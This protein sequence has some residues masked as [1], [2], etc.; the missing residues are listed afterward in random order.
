[1]QLLSL[2]HWLSHVVITQSAPFFLSQ[3]SNPLHHFF[4]CVCVTSVGFCCLIKLHAFQY[5]GSKQLVLLVKSAPGFKVL[6]INTGQLL[7]LRN[8]I[9]YCQD[10]FPSLNHQIWKELQKTPV[11]QGTFILANQHNN[12]SIEWIIFPDCYLTFIKKKWRAGKP[13]RFHE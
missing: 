1:M 12:H 8:E 3:S 10:S 7:L 4:L 9:L 13:C 5:L 2:M 6:V 11:L